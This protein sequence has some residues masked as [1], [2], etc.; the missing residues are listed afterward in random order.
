VLLPAWLFSRRAYAGVVIWAC[1]LARAAG[2]K[3]AAIG[4]LAGVAVSTVASWLR[5]VMGRAEWWRQVLMGVL[6]LVDVQVRR[7]APGGSPL[8]DALAVLEAVTTTLRAKGGPMATVTS[9]EVAS[10]LTRGHLLAPFLDLDGCN[11][12]LFWLP[13]ATPS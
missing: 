10:H 5:R 11:T 7:V 3:I 13:A 4:A 9:Q 12:S 8:A 1:V 2:M 6:A